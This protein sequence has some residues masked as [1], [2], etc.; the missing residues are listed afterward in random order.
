M[1]IMEEDKLTDL[2]M[3][4]SVDVLNLV[5]ELKSQKETIVSNQIAEA[6]QVFALILLKVNM[7]NPVLILFQS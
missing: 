5:K 4:L 6:Q 7:H 3:Q 2:S 1:I